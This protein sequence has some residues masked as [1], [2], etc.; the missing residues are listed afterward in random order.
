MLYRFGMIDLPRLRV[1]STVVATGSVSAAAVVLGYTPS[2]ISQQLTALQRE[3]KLQLVE[4]RGRGI[5]PTA[6]GCALAAEARRVLETMSGIEGLV[7]DLR[8]GRVGSLSI[9]YFAS[10]GAAWIPPVV[11]ALIREFPDLRLDL[12]LS[13]LPGHAD[14]GPD[15]EIF[16]SGSHPDLPGDL[17]AAYSVH[18]LLD[19][20]YVAVL[21]EAHAL[22]GRSNVALRELAPDRWVDNDFSRGFCRQVVLDACAEAGFAPDFRIET[23]D[24]PSAVSLVAAGVGITVLPLL[25]VGQLPPG[26]VS[27]P[28]IDPT[29][30]RRVYL[31]V[32]AAVEKRPAALRALELF[33]E[34]VASPPRPAL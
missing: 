15:L 6:A 4:R 33:R 8:A 7:G 3:T 17:T 14:T 1:L 31:A 9:R 12:R 25:G 20:P 27:L 21:P 26:V 10:A 2:A 30:V 32:K 11:A 24:Y 23:P 34:R 29:P 18:H 22:A 28:I 13:E 19:D 5:E 16:V